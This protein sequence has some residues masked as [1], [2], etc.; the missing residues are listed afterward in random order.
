[1]NVA[2]GCE[3]QAAR[4]LRAEVADN[5]AKQVASH[6]DVELPG[7][8]NHFHRQRIDIKMTRLDL[9]ILLANLLEDPLPQVMGEGHGVGLIA[10]ADTPELV[11]P[12]VFKS[13]ADDALNSFAGVHVFLNGDFVGSILFEEAA[14]ADVQAFSVLAEDHKAYVVCSAIAER[15]QSVVEKFHRTGVYEEVQLEAQA[16]KNVGSVLIGRNARIAKRAKQDG[17]EFVGQHFDRAS[18]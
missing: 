1:M 5:V 11:L 6:N 10:H 14:N 18:R 4:E 12:G 9:R 8:A 15:R 3:P 2:R 17:V 13:V 7:I 16:Q